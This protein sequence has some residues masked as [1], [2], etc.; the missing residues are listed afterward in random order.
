MGLRK[1]STT[2]FSSVWLVSDARVLASAKLASSRSAR[3]RGLIGVVDIDEPLVLQPCRWIHTFGVVHTLDVAYLDAQGVVLHIKRISPWRVD[4]PVW[5]AATVIEA[6]NGSME[7]WNLH[8]G[9]IV[10]VRHVQ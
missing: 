1:K 8:I 7:R 9:D 6:T 10:E 5:S 4:A 2:H 3:R